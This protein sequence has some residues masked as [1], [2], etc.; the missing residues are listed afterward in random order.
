ME[1]IASVMSEKL[2]EKHMG[3]KNTINLMAKL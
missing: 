2:T 1:L 3:K